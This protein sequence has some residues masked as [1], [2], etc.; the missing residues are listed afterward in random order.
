VIQELKANKGLKETRVI[1][2]IRVIQGHHH[3]LQKEPPH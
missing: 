3:N 2:V 1:R